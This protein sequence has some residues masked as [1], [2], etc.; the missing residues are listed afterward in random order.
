MYTHVH[1]CTV[2]SIVVKSTGG[3]KYRGYKLG[4]ICGNNR[5]AMCD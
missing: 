2:Y 1:C 4:N 3:Y 5:F